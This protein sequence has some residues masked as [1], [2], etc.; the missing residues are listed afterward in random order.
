[1]TQRVRNPV[2]IVTDRPFQ[3]EGVSLYATI[4]ATVQY[5]N[6]R[7]FG[8]RRRRRGHRRRGRH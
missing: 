8:R 5:R 2:H 1:M 3:T 6:L 4:G 7:L